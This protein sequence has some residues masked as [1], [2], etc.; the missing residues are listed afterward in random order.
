MAACQQGSGR[1]L[2]VPFVLPAV[3]SAQVEQ[4]SCKALTSAPHTHQG[5]TSVLAL[6]PELLLR[7]MSTLGAKQR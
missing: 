3:C 4:T 6:P 5:Q 1:A 7:I 2:E